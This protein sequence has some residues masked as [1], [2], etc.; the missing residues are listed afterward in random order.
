MN[1]VCNLFLDTFIFDVSFVIFFCV[2]CDLNVSDPEA[3]DCVSIILCIPLFVWPG[4]ND[5]PI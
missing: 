3:N 4:M 5:R 1:G 2:Q